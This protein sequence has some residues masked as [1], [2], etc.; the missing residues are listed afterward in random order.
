[1]IL[2]GSGQIVQD[3]QPDSLF[4][5]YLAQKDPIRDRCVTFR[6]RVM[7]T[8]QGYVL[9]AAFSAMKSLV[10]REIPKLTQDPDLDRM[11]LRVLDRIEMPEEVTCGDYVVSMESAALAGTEVHDTSCDHLA[12]K[13]DPQVL[14]KVAEILRGK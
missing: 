3:L 12:I 8:S 13:E 7:G 6:G 2:D 9:R 4:L 10:G 5:R 14:E 1:M 11:W